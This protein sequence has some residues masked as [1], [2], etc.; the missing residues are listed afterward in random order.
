MELKLIH[1]NISVNELLFNSSLEEPI[2]I[3]YLLP[4]YYPSIFKVLKTRIEPKIIS[5]R[6][7]GDKLVIDGSSKITIIYVAE[8]TNQIKSIIYRSSFTKTIDLKNS[9]DNPI[10]SVSGKCDYVNCRVI[11]PKR[12]DIKSA[13][14]LR[15]KVL[16]QVQKPIVS[17]VDCSG[18]QL[19][20]KMLSLGIVRKDAQKLFNV[21]ENIC[22]NC[23]DKI[24]SLVFTQGEC[25]LT[26]KKIIANK[27]ILK[28]EVIINMVYSKGDESELHHDCKRVAVSQIVDMIGIS[29]EYSCFAKVELTNIELEPL[30]DQGSDD[31]KNEYSCDIE[32][33]V[34]CSA[35]LSKQLQVIKDAYC[36]CFDTEI[37]T[38]IINNEKYC[39]ELDHN[40]KLHHT[41]PLNDMECTKLYYSFADFMASGVR[42]IDGKLVI[43]GS[44]QIISIGVDGDNMPQIIEK[45]IDCHI[46]TNH[47]YFKHAINIDVEINTVAADVRIV[48]N[49]LDIHVEVNV[50]GAIYHL[51]EEKIITNIE[52]CEDKPKQRINDCALTVYYADAGEYVWDIARKYNT[53]IQAIMIENELEQDIIEAR[54]MLL[55]PIVD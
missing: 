4:D 11:N 23:N 5:K 26:D 35:F 46:S 33:N 9:C 10:I 38:G 32:L 53:N 2:D 8:Q 15:V 12:I 41:V 37:E 49:K 6:I 13:V 28:G 3:D 48:D 34:S 40:C 19:K 44:L 22:I 55:I 30:L 24:G 31:N 47:E 43:D 42:D 54:S 18:I 52:I 27:L 45:N 16:S 50:N 39:G 21:K 25:I 14:T 20:K 29:D 36:T 1:E 17:D 7:S 51:I